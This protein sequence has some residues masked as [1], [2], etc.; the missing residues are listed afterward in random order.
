MP[1]G[2]GEHGGL[3]AQSSIAPELRL[4]EVALVD[5]GLVRGLVLQALGVS[6]LTP[7]FASTIRGSL[8]Y[9]DHFKDLGALDYSANVFQ[10]FLAALATGSDCT[11]RIPDMYV[12]AQRAG[13]R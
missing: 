3:E 12:W 8:V 2:N 6:E 5:R 11:R 4:L 9:A 7:S 13:V 1:N 10:N